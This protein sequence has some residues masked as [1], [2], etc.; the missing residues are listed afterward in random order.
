M[1]NISVHLSGHCQPLNRL[2]N[3]FMKLYVEVP[4]KIL[5]SKSEL[6]ENPR[7]ES[8]AVVKGVNDFQSVLSI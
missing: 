1:K 3:Y 5:S 6:S 4:Y 7:S 2:S 8:H